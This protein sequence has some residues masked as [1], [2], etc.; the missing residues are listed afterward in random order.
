MLLQMVGFGLA[1]PA[2]VYYVDRMLPVAERARGQGMMTLTLTLGNVVAG[3]AGGVLLDLAGVPAL[4]VAGTVA[5]VLGAVAVFAGT[6]R[7]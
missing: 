1:I 7:R 3:L 2:T 6:S 5:A 4:L